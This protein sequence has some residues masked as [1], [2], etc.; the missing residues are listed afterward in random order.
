MVNLVLSHGCIV[1]YTVR[2]NK[3]YRVD[4]YDNWR[5]LAI[6][7]M[8]NL[9]CI[10]DVSMITILNN[11][12]VMLWQ[13]LHNSSTIVHDS[14]YECTWLDVV[15]VW[16][17]AFKADLCHS[18]CRITLKCWFSNNRTMAGWLSLR[19]CY[20]QWYDYRQSI[21]RLTKIVTIVK[22]LILIYCEI[23]VQSSMNSHDC[24]KI[25]CVH[26]QSSYTNLTITQDP[27]WFWSILL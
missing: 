20:E 4:N 13:I 15:I 8:I 23:Y 5:F 3:I 9:W 12:M 26:V 7:L 2:M 19:L 10:Y 22:R 18:L 14:S 6:H 17:N 1:R 16:Y 21:V 25:N 24:F 11:H 27:L